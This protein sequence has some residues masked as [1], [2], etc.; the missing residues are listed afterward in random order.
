MSVLRRVF[1][2]IVRFF[3]KI[4]FII[5]YRDHGAFHRENFP[6]DDGTPILFIAAPHGNFLMDAITIFVTCPRNMYFLSAK[7][8][9]NYPVFGTIITILG[10]IPVTRPQDAERINGDGLIRV[11]G[12]GKKVT[13]EGLGKVLQVGDTLYVEF[14][15]PNDNEMLKEASGTVEE[16]IDDDS[17]RIKEPGMKWLTKGR[18]KGKFRRL[19]EYGNVFIRVERGNTIKTLE[20]LNFI[21]KS[22]TQSVS[23]SWDKLSSS[24]GKLPFPIND[25][26][27]DEIVV[28]PQNPEATERTPLLNASESSSHNKRQPSPR[29]TSIYKPNFPSV[30]DIPTTYSYIHMP[31]HSEVY[32]AVY[33]HFSKSQ[34]V[35][36]FPEGTSHDNEHMLSLKYGCAVMSLGYL[37][38]KE[39]DA[40]GKE[41]KLKIVPCGLNFFNRH[42]FR[43]RVF[44][45]VGQPIEIEQ[46]LVDLYK[47]GGDGKRQACQELLKTIQTSLSELTVNAPD[48]NT[49][50]FFKTASRLYRE[51]LPNELSFSKKLELLRK[52]AKKYTANIP[53]TDEARKLK[54]DVVFYIQKLRSHRL[55]PP[56]MSTTPASLFLYLPL[57][58]ILFISTMPGLI[59]FSPIGVIAKYVG[60]KQGENA[61]LYDDNSLAITRW[62][63]RDVIATWKMMTGLVLFITFDIIYS[64]IMVHFIRR[65]DLYE[66]HYR[67]DVFMLGFCIF[68]F[69][70]TVI[71]YATILLWERLCWV[72]KRVWVGVWSLFNPRERKSLTSWRNELTDRVCKWVDNEG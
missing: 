68:A 59:L 57:L 37:A 31:P 47:S 52:I 54:N 38:S 33:N 71:A 3:A 12:E 23:R 42:R 9:F 58:V 48:Y 10:C 21:P 60:K 17:V 26:Q 7:S 18:R 16:I 64:I 34:C 50:L 51:N 29:P 39:P 20:G 67:K 41:R 24:P 62:P 30:P 69:F 46:R 70:W 32:S 27:P 49:L 44:I 19:V 5:F 14:E 15:R 35:A 61:M 65:Y 25:D 56:H 40:F 1:Y 55:S 22:V 28:C 63:G 13:G 45:D 8:N 66:I 53:P 2:S 43:S 4:I 11:V 72:G 36:I 6:K